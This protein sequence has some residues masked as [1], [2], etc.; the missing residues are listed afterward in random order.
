MN[1]TRSSVSAAG[2]RVLASLLAAFVALALLAVPAGAEER[3]LIRGGGWGHGIGMSQ[4]GAYGLAQRGKSSGAILK[5]YYRGVDVSRRRMPHVRVGLLQ[6]DSSI[7][8]SSNG[9]KI[10]FKVSGTKGSIA[11]GNASD[12]WSLQPSPTGRI[13]LFKNGDVIVRNGRRAFG[14]PSKPML[15]LYEDFGSTVS[16]FDKSNSYRY[17][18]LEVGSYSSSS[19]GGGYCLRLVLK[20]SMQKYL[21]GLGEVPSSWP[22]AV[23]QAQAIAGRTYAYR[24]IQAYGQ[25]T[26]PCDCAVVDSVYDQAYI[27]DAKRTGSG[28]YWDDWKQAVNKTDEKVILHDGAPIQ[29]LY[30]SSS[31]GYTENNENVWGG[32]PLPYLRGVKDPGDKVSVNPN[33]HWSITMSRSE[34]SSKLNAAYGIGTLKKFELVKPFGVSGR[35]T[36]VKSNGGGV[37]IVGTNR[38]VR[39]SGWSIRSALGLKDTLFR[40]TFY[41]P[42]W[43]KLQNKYEKLNGAP[44]VATSDAYYVP[45]GTKRGLG[46]AQNFEQGRMTWRRS[47]GESVWQWGKV[48]RKYNALGRERSALGMPNSDVWGPGWFRGGSYANGAIVWSRNNGAFAVLGKWKKVYAAKGWVRGNLGVP[49]SARGRASTL[50]N[51]GLRQKFANGRMYGPPQDNSVYALWGKI[52]KRYG[53]LGE[54]K[55]KCGYPT[56]HVHATENGPRAKFRHGSISV[57]ASGD[58]EV[59][60]G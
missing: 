24:K 4:Y 59:D 56:S 16:V 53:A 51:G 38:T 35:V 41:F 2:P 34:L 27:G 13:K 37:R 18:R 6:Y 39:E 1:M 15:V 44:G 10:K 14:G 20:T 22:N 52:A 9:G 3:V 57:S 30:S 49:T 11:T 17:G 46:R 50:P 12:S 28:Q 43:S 58:V 40:I 7:G 31:G 45:K 29:A 21:Y 42:V 19:C 48:L 26:S 8:M 55:S 25:H 54:A 32:T 36:V 60:C 47:T 23:L 33:H 5:H